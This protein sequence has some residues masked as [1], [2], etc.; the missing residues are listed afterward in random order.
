[1]YQVKSGIG[2]DLP[3]RLELVLS[4]GLVS[5]PWSRNSSNKPVT[6][7]H[8]TTQ[9]VSLCC[10]GESS[11]GIFVAVIGRKRIVVSVVMSVM[12][13]AQ[14][15][16]SRGAWSE[17]VAHPN[18]YNVAGMGTTSSQVSA[19]YT[20]RLSACYTARLSACYTARL[21]ACY[22]AFPEHCCNICNIHGVSGA[23]VAPCSVPL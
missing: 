9:E 20:A 2:T 16:C 11:T 1:M 14:G 12:Y 18:G 21:S 17:S 19:C 4:L 8:D 15:V 7:Y 10:V 6:E 3:N 22:T 5:M 23:H 13:L